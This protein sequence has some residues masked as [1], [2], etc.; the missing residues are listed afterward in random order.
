MNKLKKHWRQKRR[1]NSGDSWQTREP[2]LAT[3]SVRGAD[4]GEHTF[5]GDLPSQTSPLNPFLINEVSKL[6]AGSRPV[7]AH[8]LEKSLV[9]MEQE[10]CGGCLRRGKQAGLRVG[11]QEPT[12]VPPVTESALEVSAWPLGSHFEFRSH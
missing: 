12:W 6:H 4:K 2:P 3:G 9:V 7:P 11:S 1:N 8:R 10:L 5:S